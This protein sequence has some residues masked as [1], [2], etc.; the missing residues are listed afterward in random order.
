MY[1][2]AYVVLQVSKSRLILA[3]LIF[4]RGNAM[5]KPPRAAAGIEKQALRPMGQG[6][7]RSSVMIC[8]LVFNQD[9]WEGISASAT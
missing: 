3:Q 7:A 5:R 1:V 9:A 6:N 2:R 4:P 8:R